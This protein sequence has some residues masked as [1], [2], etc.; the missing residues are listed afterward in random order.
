MKS[1]DDEVKINKKVTSFVSKID[2]IGKEQRVNCMKKQVVHD[3]VTLLYVIDNAVKSPGVKENILTDLN[4][5][6]NVQ[7][8]RKKEYFQKNNE[9]K[10]VYGFAKKVVDNMLVIE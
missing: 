6:M 10:A 1:K 2:G 7:A 3:F 5:F 9:L 4:T 8:V